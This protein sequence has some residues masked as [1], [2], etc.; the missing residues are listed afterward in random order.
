M[1]DEL[2]PS[3]R[4]ALRARIVGGAHDI[5]PVGAHRNAW[6]AGSVAAA[7][8]V[9][10]AGGVAVTSTL[11]APEIATTPSPSPTVT[12]APVPT[13][14]ASP[15]ATS[16]AAPVTARPRVAFGGDCDQVLSLEEVSNIIGGGDASLLP[17]ASLASNSAGSLSLLGGVSCNWMTATEYVEVVVASADSVD[18]EFAA[19]LSQIDC[20]G[21]ACVAGRTAGDLWIGV[22]VPFLRANAPGGLPESDVSDALART[23]AITSAVARKP[24]SAPAPAVRATDATNWVLSDCDA[25]RPKL[26]SATGEP[27]TENFPDGGSP[28]EG[29]L[30]Q[31]LVDSSAG[32]TGCAFHS[33]DQESRSFVTVRLMPGVTS[34]G[35]PVLDAPNTFETSVTGADRAWAQ[36]TYDHVY[37][38]DLMAVV[39]QNS[40][41]VQRMTAEPAVTDGEKIA[42]EAIDLVGG[43]G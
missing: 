24:H 26:E 27:L 16:T 9:A 12:A 40:V 28:L 41:V 32:V 23:D 25:L 11:S 35:Q 33:T 36:T 6:I 15:T 38:L 1:N 31:Q 17:S 8:V 39:G 4:A 20:S 21:Y 5:K 13:P 34:P 30:A 10:I 29:D 3:E 43:R 19:S 42:A 7:M 37:A 18:R 22:R 14:T 2:T